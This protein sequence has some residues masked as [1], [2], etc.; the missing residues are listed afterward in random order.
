MSVNQQAMADNRKADQ[1]DW[2]TREDQ[3]FINT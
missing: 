3:S 1:A 2:E